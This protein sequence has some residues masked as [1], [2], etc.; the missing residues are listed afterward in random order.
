MTAGP[1]D[2]QARAGQ[3]S[4]PLA[5]HG[6]ERGSLEKVVGGGQGE[7]AC[8]V[9]DQVQGHSVFEPPGPQAF[10]LLLPHAV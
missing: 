5:W 9:R 10:S 2:G 1:P 7:V 6:M 3:L 4:A 8:G